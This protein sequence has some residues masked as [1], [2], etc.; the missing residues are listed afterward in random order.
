MS[1]HEFQSKHKGQGLSKQEISMRWEEYKNANGIK[2]T[3]RRKKKSAD[4]V[5]VRTVNESE[6]MKELGRRSQIESGEEEMGVSLPEKASRT[7]SSLGSLLSKTGLIDCE[8]LEEIVINDPKNIVNASY[9]QNLWNYYRLN[10]PVSL[11]LYPDISHIKE[12]SSDQIDQYEDH[13]EDLYPV[14]DEFLR[15]PDKRL[16]FIFDLKNALQLIKHDGDL[17]F[18]KLPLSTETI[19]YYINITKENAP[20]EHKVLITLDRCNTEFLVQADGITNHQ[21]NDITN[22]QS[23]SITNHQDN[24]ITHHRSNSITNHQGGGITDR[25]GLYDR[26]V[27]VLPSANNP[28][29]NI[30]S[31]RDSTC[32]IC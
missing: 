28:A 19:N 3:S 24:D 29:M 23:N 17:F 1:W 25:Q 9:I 12:P 31:K 13:L 21:D 22:H 10:D 26:Y 11:D 18:V 32:T 30:P 4:D 8:P 20:E 7:K 15:S 14:F 2:T 6:T 5:S 16:N 27:G